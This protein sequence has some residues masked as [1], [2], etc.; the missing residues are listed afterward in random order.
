MQK[1]N[2]HT[3]MCEC[4]Y[5]CVTQHWHINTKVAELL[6]CVLPLFI[7]FME[8]KRYRFQ[9]PLATG[10][11]KMKQKQPWA[12]QNTSIRVCVCV[13]VECIR[14][15]YTNTMNNC[16]RVNSSIQWVP[17]FLQLAFLPFLHFGRQHLPKANGKGNSRTPASLATGL[18]MMA[19]HPFA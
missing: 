7:L 13:C 1:T 18:T 19:M 10:R 2:T 5:V 9:A 6:P 12:K 4:A 3:Q 16:E 15:T 17:S 11:H 8:D 14:I